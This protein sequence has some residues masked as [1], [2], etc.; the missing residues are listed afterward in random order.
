MGDRM[1]CRDRRAQFRVLGTLLVAMAVLSWQPGPFAQTQTAVQINGAGA[2]FPYP[3]YSSWFADYAKV[4]PD[5]QINY[6]SIGS[7]AGI[8]QISELIVFFAATDT[9][10]DEDEFQAA[11][12]RIL[13]LPMV[14]G[15]VAPIYNVP[16]LADGVKFDGTVLADIYLGKIRNWNDPAIARLNE[17]VTLPPTEITVVSRAES[18]G[19]AFIFSDY[20][21]KIS[22]E[23]RRLFG[24][25]RHPRVLVGVSAR[26]S[27]GVAALVKQTPGA[28]GYVELTYA[29]R[30]KIHM[31]V[32]RNQ[33]GEFVR[34]SVEGAA[35]AAQAAVGLMPR[36]FRVSITNA[37]GAGVY[38]ISS[39]TWLLVYQNAR[40]K[41]R[42]RLMVDFMKWALTDGQSRAAGLGYAPLPPAI[43]T[44]EMAALGT[45]KVS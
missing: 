17:G 6:L 19:T 12:G 34:P 7:G 11:P 40:D 45:I 8:R 28:I 31:G 43:V 15:A 38:P 26:G 20:L 37:P 23:W 10:M 24:A 5:V 35:A 9:P 39:F 27:E 29:L 4:K 13:H 42:S 18:S 41:K 1:S 3:I 2:T 16:G 21:S 36:D 44:L 14:V 25:N 30:E 22:P 33:V 32:V